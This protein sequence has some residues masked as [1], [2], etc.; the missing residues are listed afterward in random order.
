[1]PTNDF[2]PGIIPVF[3]TKW[4]ARFYAW[5]ARRRGFQTDIHDYGAYQRELGGRYEVRLSA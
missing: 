3:M 4:G 1:M 5:R 2:S